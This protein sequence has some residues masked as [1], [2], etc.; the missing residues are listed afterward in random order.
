MAKIRLFLLGLAILMAAGLGGCA[1][2]HFGTFRTDLREP[3]FSAEGVEEALKRGAIF[4]LLAAEEYNQR[5][6]FGRKPGQYSPRRP[7]GGDYREHRPRYRY[8]Y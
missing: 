1:S 8:H 7:P 2:E 5:D 6:R 4:G 3:D